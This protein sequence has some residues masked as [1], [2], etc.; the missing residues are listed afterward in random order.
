[1]AD[2][3][4]NPRIGAKNTHFMTGI[5]GV[6][7]QMVAVSVSTDVIDDDSAQL[8]DADGQT[9]VE[10]ASSHYRAATSGDLA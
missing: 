3:L 2:T 1:M 10:D 7:D 4:V 8:L 9:M 6:K 5:L